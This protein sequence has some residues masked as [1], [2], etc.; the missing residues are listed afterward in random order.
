MLQVSQG[1]CYMGIICHEALV[2]STKSEEA[3]DFCDISGRGPFPDGD[4][5]L[6]LGSYT[7]FTHNKAAV[8]DFRLGKSTFIL[9]C[10]EM[11]LAE[12]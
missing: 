9:A 6:G 4:Q 7:L 11:L 10:I 3:T 1:G 5:F 12:F 2:E 8:F